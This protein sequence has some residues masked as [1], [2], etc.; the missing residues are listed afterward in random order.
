VGWQLAAAALTGFVAKENVVSTFAILLLAA[1][2][3]ALHMPGGVLTELFTPVTAYAYL[4]FNLFTPPCFAAIGAMNSEMG[5]KKWLLKG[6]GFQMAVGFT[7]ATIIAQFGSLILYGERI[8]GFVPGM[9]FLAAMAVLV[10][11]LVRKGNQK[12]LALDAAE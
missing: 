10:L 6:L 2:E 7:V 3:D 1:S 11:L 5:S 4:A 8:V 12:R 9:L